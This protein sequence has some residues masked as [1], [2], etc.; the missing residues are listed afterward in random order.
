MK[1]FTHLSTEQLS[2]QTTIIGLSHKLL[3]EVYDGSLD[4]VLELEELHTEMVTEIARRQMVDAPANE[5][6][7]IR[8]VPA[9]PVAAV[10]QVVQ[11][12]TQEAAAPIIMAE[13][14]RTPVQL[15]KYAKAE[16]A[17][18]KKAGLVSYF[19]ITGSWVSGTDG[20]SFNA[21]VN[22]KAKTVQIWGVNTNHTKGPFEFNRTFK[23]GD[24]CEYDSFNFAYTG[25]ITSIGAKTITVDPGKGYGAQTRLSLNEFV[26]RNYKFDLNK[27]ANERRAWMD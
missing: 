23:I 22:L 16:V 10:A 14:P 18:D 2:A 15:N 12:A 21:T 13:G 24:L 4:T 25:N 6:K 19:G 8:M 27:I 20:S 1:N 9:S 5:A 17:E 7:V 3:A 11:E 26:G